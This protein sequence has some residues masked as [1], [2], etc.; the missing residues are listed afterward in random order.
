MQAQIINAQRMVVAKLGVAEGR[1]LTALAVVCAVVVVVAAGSVA[2]VRRWLLRP[3]AQLH[4]AAEAVAAGQYDT[5]VPAVGP[6]ELAE[7]GRATERMRIQL[8]ARARP[9]T[10]PSTPPARPPARRRPPARSG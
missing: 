3:F 5:R 6:A 10:S 7:L 9:F 1:L 8:V 4:R 2:A